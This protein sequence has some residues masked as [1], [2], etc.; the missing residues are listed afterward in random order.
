MN[1][2]PYIIE[3]ISNLWIFSVVAVILPAAA[4]F[5]FLF[6]TLIEWVCR[7]EPVEEP[8]SN[9]NNEGWRP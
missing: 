3:A 7:E 9:W 8:D 2:L 1:P 4:L 5:K 6:A